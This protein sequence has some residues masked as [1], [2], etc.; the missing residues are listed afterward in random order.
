MVCL[1]LYLYNA[2]STFH[3]YDVVLYVKLQIHVIIIF[4]GLP[5]RSAAEAATVETSLKDGALIRESYKSVVDTVIK[6]CESSLRVEVAA[7]DIVVA[8][9][10]K[11]GVNDKCRP[12]IVRFTNNEARNNVFYAKKN[13]KSPNNP[14]PHGHVSEHLTRSASELFYVSRK[15]FREHKLH[16]TWTKQGIV[17][18]KMTDARSELPTA[19]R[20]M[21]DFPP[22]VRPNWTT[23]L[24]TI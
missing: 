23:W 22:E 8:H 15:L 12:I 9:R 16:A 11:K 19:I 5:E 4:R 13:L 24:P 18:V 2:T 1:F 14:N 3:N 6:F 17:Y 20:K 21:T 7:A 10:L